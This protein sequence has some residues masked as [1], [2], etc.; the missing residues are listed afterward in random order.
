MLSEAEK[1]WADV[2]EYIYAASH[3]YVDT[4]VL[5]DAFIKRIVK[6]GNALGMDFPVTEP[7]ARVDKAYIL[8]EERVK[9]LGEYIDEA[10]KYSEEKEIT[11][12]ICKE[13]DGIITEMIIP[14]GTD[15][16]A[17]TKLIGRSDDINTES[18]SKATRLTLWYGVYK[19]ADGRRVQF[20]EE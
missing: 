15:G 10:K 3:P 5:I 2:P 19:T 9:G 16:K 17:L 14:D 20:F 13:R 12:T 18:T 4:G 6:I 7:A 1:L 8:D 11:M